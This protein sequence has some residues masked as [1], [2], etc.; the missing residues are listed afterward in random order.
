MLQT[1]KQRIAVISWVCFC[2]PILQIFYKLQSI[3]P[4][5]SNASLLS[6]ECVFVNPSC[7]YVT[8][9]KASNPKATH[10][11]NRSE[12]VCF[13]KPILQICYKL[14]SIKPFDSN[15][16]RLSRECVFVNPSCKY[17]TNYK[18]S[19]QTATHRC[20]RSE[21]VCFCKP[22]LQIC[23]KLQT[24]PEIPESRFIVF[25]FKRR[26]VPVCASLNRG[27]RGLTTKHQTI[28]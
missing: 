20:N 1:T 17:V 23:Y 2:K 18:A 15:A 16:S 12:C 24:V 13:C 26:F 8:N 11:C 10:R 5:D 28:R 7:K 4:F 21:C 19:N 14:Q 22:I 3:K 6:R 25:A 9:Y 27:F